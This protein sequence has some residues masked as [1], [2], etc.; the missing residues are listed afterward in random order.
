MEEVYVV[1][2]R[3]LM[4]GVPIR[5]LAREMGVAKN[6]IKRYLRG[7]APGVGKPRGIRGA[8]VRDAV[9]SRALELLEDSKHW[10]AGKQRLT[11][12][13]LHTMLHSDGHDVGYT[14]VKD[15]VREWKRQRKEVFVPLV[16]KPV[17]LDEV[18]FFEVLVDVAGERARRTCS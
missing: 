9:Q 16:Y 11:A 8:P 6:T 14:V 2:H 4:E 10:T 13:R 17:D 5:R 7:A 3:H 1:R 12:A 18:D 15:I